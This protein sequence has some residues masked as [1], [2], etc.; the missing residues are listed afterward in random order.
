MSHSLDLF[1][2]SRAA[3]I[4]EEQALLFRAWT[5]ERV[6]TDATQ[7]GRARGLRMASAATYEDMWRVFSNWCAPRDRRLATIDAQALLAFLDSLGRS[8][9]ATGRYR[10]R[11]LQLIR[12]LDRYEARLKRRPVNAQIVAALTADLRIFPRNGDDSPLPEFLTVGQSQRLID[13]LTRKHSPSGTRRVWQGLRNRC[14]LA[15]QL[16][17]GLTPGEVLALRLDQLI[18]EGG[19]RAGIPWALRLSANGNIDARETPLAGWAGELLAQWLEIRAK[20]SIP[21]EQVFP[22]TQQG[23]VWGKASAH[24]VQLAELEAAGVKGLSGTFPLRHTFAVRQL[25]RFPVDQVQRWMGLRDPLSM[26]RYKRVLASP[27]EVV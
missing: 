6:D 8:G 13:H 22:S 15:V 27:V 7:T 20:F 24:R 2:D 3:T 25:T 17:A 10:R 23:S 11:M 5:A 12:T 19:Q 18:V 9:L 21:G 26:E 14:A 16:G 1:P 4:L